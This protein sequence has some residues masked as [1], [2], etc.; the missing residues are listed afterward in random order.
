MLVDYD[1][2]SSENCSSDEIGEIGDRTLE[3]ATAVSNLDPDSVKSVASSVH[4][5]SKEQKAPCKDESGAIKI[6]TAAELFGDDE[7]STA[8]PGDNKKEKLHLGGAKRKQQQSPLGQQGT[9]NTKTKGNGCTLLIPQ[10]VARNVS[11]TVTEDTSSFSDIAQRRRKK[12][13]RQ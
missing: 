2:S 6:P 12:V 11:N 4:I 1:S 13:Q 10:H 5:V 9:Q 3:R 7:E 8:R